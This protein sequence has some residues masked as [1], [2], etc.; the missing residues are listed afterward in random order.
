MS[1]GDQPTVL[2]AAI[3]NPDR[4]D[5]GVGPAIAA[6]LRRSVPA[7]VRIIE[8]SG[9]ILALI[10]EWDGFSDVF[11]VDAAAATGR[12]GRIRRLDLVARPLPD[13]VAHGSTHAFGVGEAVELA[14]SLNRLPRRLVAYLVEGERFDI[15][16]ALSA[17]VAASVGIVAEQI[18]DEVARI[19]A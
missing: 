9:D 3:G 2:V 14:R 11:V 4:G 17:A 8:R 12:P 18:R 15:G 16:M 13:G 5:D 1:G 7:G 6:R 19:S 10:E